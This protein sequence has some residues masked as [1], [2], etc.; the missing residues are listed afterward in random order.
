MLYIIEWHN[1]VGQKLFLNEQ[2]FLLWTK[3]FLTESKPFGQKKKKFEQNQN[4]LVQIEIDISLL[5]PFPKSSTS[6]LFFLPG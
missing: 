2:N 3:T 5:D 4:F 6:V 1:S